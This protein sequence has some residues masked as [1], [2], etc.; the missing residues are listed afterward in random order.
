MQLDDNK[1]LRCGQCC[2]HFID[3][4]WQSCKY[5][6]KISKDKFICRIYKNRIN[7]VVVDVPGLKTYCCWRTQVNLNFPGCPYNVE[8]QNMSDE[9]RFI[10]KGDGVD[11]KEKRSES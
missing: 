6:K 8:G 2:K 7:H 11:E 1:C 4:K 5:L 10:T 3:G 9:S